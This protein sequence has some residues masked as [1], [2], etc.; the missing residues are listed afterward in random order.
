MMNSRGQF[1]ILWLLPC[2]AAG[3]AVSEEINPTSPPVVSLPH[4]ELTAPVDLTQSSWPWQII[5]IC[6]AIAIIAAIVFWLLFYNKNPKSGPA[7]PPLTLARERLQ[8][9]LDE[10]DDFDHAE[11]G[12]RVSVI[13]RDYQMGRY[14][15]P[16][17]FRTREELYDQ[18]GFA[19]EE[20][21]RERFAAIALTCDQVAF[22]PA[23]TT[24][25]EAESLVMSAIEALNNEAPPLEVTVPN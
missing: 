19:A 17:P 4:P 1:H 9:L 6:T 24:R 2:I 10:L 22:A 15:V 12:H 21:H 25:S 13:M 7:V 14:A 18:H 5:L 20:E 16:A 3:G 8:K 11:I 23:P